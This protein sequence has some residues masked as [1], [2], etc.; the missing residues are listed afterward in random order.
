M[1]ATASATDALGVTRLQYSTDNGANYIDAPI[2]PGTSVS[3]SLPAVTNEGATSFR[4]R[5][6]DAAGNIA[7]GVPSA[8]SL[9]QPAAAG[10]TAVRLASTGGRA[11]ATTWSSTSEPSTR[12]RSRSR[13][14]S[15]PRL[16]PRTPT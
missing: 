5:A 8:T 10:A 3:F 14:S 12:R 11:S 2:T 15:R 7:R 16:R 1:T 9:N 4:V 6:Y 13:A